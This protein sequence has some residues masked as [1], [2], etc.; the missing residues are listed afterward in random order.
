MLLFI[1]VN[2]QNYHEIWLATLD[3]CKSVNFSV[4]DFTFFL[5]NEKTT[6]C[7]RIVQILSAVDSWVFCAGVYLCT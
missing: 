7:F 4:L 6:T 5:V 3:N 1:K 2:L